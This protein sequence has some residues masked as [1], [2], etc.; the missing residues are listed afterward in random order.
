MTYLILETDVETVG[1]V[2]NQYTN[3]IVKIFIHFVKQYL[4]MFGTCLICTDFSDGLERLIDF[5]PSLASSGLKQI[6]FFHSV[7]L[8]EEGNIPRIDSE[9]T[10]QAKARLSCALK[11]VPNSV[12]VKIEVPSGSPL[13]TIPRVLEKYSIDVILLGTPIRS[14]LQEKVFGST[15][16]GLAKL[17]PKPLMIFRPQLISTYTREELALRCQHLW[18]YLLIPYNDSKSARYLLEQIKKYA[19]QRPENSLKQCMLITVI[20]DGGRRGMPLDY[21]LKEAQAKLESVKVELEEIGLEVNLEVRVG[22][23]LQEIIQASITFD[24][25]AIAIAT[26]YRGNILDWTVPSFSND[27]LHNSWFPVLFFSPKKSRNLFIL[28]CSDPE[29]SVPALVLTTSNFLI[30]LGLSF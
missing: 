13:E 22:N 16:T 26:D 2:S 11:E 6:V 4:Y 15:S 28:I 9:K 23:P 1:W 25:S 5:V 12:E 10:E 7:P 18:R 30:I 17:T 19:R 24:I 27:V 20:D 14:S 21:K 8:W 3:I 29:K